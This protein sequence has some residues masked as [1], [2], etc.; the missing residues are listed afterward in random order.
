MLGY[1]GGGY[2][3][4]GYSSEYK[5]NS[6][7]KVPFWQGPSLPPTPPQGVPGGL[8]RCAIPGGEANPPGAQ[9]LPRVLE[10]PVAA[11]K[12]AEVTAFGH[13]GV[14]GRRTDPRWVRA[15]LLALLQGLPVRELLGQDQ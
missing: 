2:G 8:G 1:G 3:A 4:G 12:V 9:L 13:P 5:C 15:R 6:M 11:S 10:L 14:A 7:V